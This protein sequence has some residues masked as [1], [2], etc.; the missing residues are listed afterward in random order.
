MEDI[1]STYISYLDKLP[2]MHYEIYFGLGNAYY[3]DYQFLKAQ[4]YYL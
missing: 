1:H 4:K 3:N 2:E